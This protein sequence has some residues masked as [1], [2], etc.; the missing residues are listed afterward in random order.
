M[1]TSGPALARGSLHPRITTALCA[2]QLAAKGCDKLFGLFVLGCMVWHGLASAVHRA[3]TEQS[4]ASSAE[5]T[6]WS[7]TGMYPTLN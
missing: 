2:Q 7:R 4:R 5:L 3:V 1:S 6:L